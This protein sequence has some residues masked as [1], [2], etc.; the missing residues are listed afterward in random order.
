VFRILDPQENRYIK[1]GATTQDDV[2]DRIKQQ[3]RCYGG[4]EKIFPPKSG[5]PV[6]VNHVFQVEKLVHA[7]LENKGMHLRCAYSNCRNETHREWLEVEGDHAVAVIQKWS[8]W[9]NRSPFE[10]YPIALLIALEISPKPNV[11]RPEE[12]GAEEKNAERVDEEGTNAGTATAKEQAKR[13]WGLKLLGL[14][15]IVGLC[16]PLDSSS[17]ARR[18]KELDEIRKLMRRI[19][20]GEPS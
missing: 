10:K 13:I 14:E 19:R 18:D 4:C 9:M 2:D 17:A 6:P 15:L 11:Q 5:R 12:L 8:H 7:E 3:K 20:L 1:I 16:S